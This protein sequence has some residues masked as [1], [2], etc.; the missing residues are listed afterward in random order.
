MKKRRTADEVARLLRE[1][2]RDLAKGLTIS[3][4]CRKINIA[5]TTYSRWRQRHDPAQVNADRRCRELEGEVERLKRLVAELMLD[6]QMLQDIAKK[7]W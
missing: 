5:E 2:D 4:V 1:I 3:D 7:K 6:K